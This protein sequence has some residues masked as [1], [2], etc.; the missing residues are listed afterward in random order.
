[1]ATI[2]VIRGHPLLD[3]A[4]V[5]AVRQWRYEPT[6]LNGVAVPVIATATVVF[7]PGTSTTTP[8]LSL[9]VNPQG[10]LR[11][12]DGS[13]ATQGQ[14]DGSSSL[15]LTPDRAIPYAVLEQ[16]LQS[17]QN[18]QIPFRLASS[19]YT[20]A[21]GRLFYNAPP[22]GADAQLVQITGIDPGIT[23]ATLDVDLERL[24]AMAKSSGIFPANGGVI[25]YTVYVSERGEIVDVRDGSPRLPEIVTALR[26]ARVFA[27]GRR[28]SQPVATAVPIRIPL[29]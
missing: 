7:N 13:P 23:A 25:G 3:Q 16:T 29:R 9:G 18:R 21:A 2:R 28:G 15:Q 5:D 4:A 26:Q 17:L 22:A 6:Y 24:A 19:T 1:V 20:F 14:L 11:N 10:K 12:L 27:A 8:A